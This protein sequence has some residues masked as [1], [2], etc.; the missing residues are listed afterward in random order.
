MDELKQILTL[1][2]ENLR[3]NISPEEMEKEGFVS[4]EHT[5]EQLKSMNDA[6]GHIIA[7]ENDRVIGYALCMHPKFADAIEMLRP[8]FVEIEKI[9]GN[10]M[11]YMV[12]GQICVAK[13]H[14]GQG[15]FKN[16]YLTMKEKLPTGFDTIVTE[17]D[18]KNIRSLNAHRAV[19]FELLKVYRSG[20]KEWHLI[21]L[22]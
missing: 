13:T 2:Q 18:A 12:M 6:C 10:Q 5:L 15:I 9:R 17:V 21:G 16:L 14:R 22:K 7:V 3:K 11:D 1:Q 20:D 4:V 8:M 19:G